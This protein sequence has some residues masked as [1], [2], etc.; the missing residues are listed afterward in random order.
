[1]LRI[2]NPGSDIDGFI[3]IFRELFD[4]LRTLETFDPDDMSRVLV[5]RNLVTSSGF[6]G[7]AALARSYRRDR[8][9]DA[10]YNQSK[11][12]SE[13]LKALGWIHPTA[14]AALKFKF[15]YLGAHAAVARRDP[16]AF[17]SECLLGIVYPNKVLA[18][19]GDL[20]LRPFTA[21]LRTMKALDGLL[22]RDEMIVGPLCLSDDRDEA[23][24]DP[25]LEMLRRIRRN[26]S[27]FVELEQASR[28]WGITLNT[29][30]NYTRFPM[31]ALRWTGW[32]ERKRV[33]DIYGLSMP[34]LV[35]TDKGRRAIAH[36]DLLSDI[37]S[38]DVSSL[39]QDSKDSVVRLGFYQLLDRA[40][41]D[42]RALDD[43]ID[44]DR[45]RAASALSL[46]DPRVLFSP[47]QELSLSYLATVFPDVSGATQR[48]ESGSAWQARAERVTPVTF[49]VTVS[50]AAGHEASNQEVR[51]LFENVLSDAHDRKAAIDELSRRYRRSN[52]DEFYPLVASLFC[53]LGYVCELSRP[54]VN[55]QR[56]DA[57][58]RDSEHTIPIEIKSPGEE[59]CLSV[60]AVR[61]ALENKVVLLARRPF[62]T[63]RH[64]TSLV[65]GYKLPADRS[66]VFSLI[67]DIRSAYDLV[68]G[69]LDFNSL[70]RLAAMTVLDG[71]RHDHNALTN[72]YGIA[73]VSDV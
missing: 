55:A 25:M 8:S 14:Q 7:A 41:F 51:Q 5:E 9:R 40:G 59:E 18:A 64:T 38:D 31:A 29:M 39:S 56:Y 22:C 30:A 61:Q 17:F 52:R 49:R 24:I 11:M 66:E 48:D 20:R 71:K 4:A 15:T 53:A 46:D 23:A 33:S 54:G 47:F 45:R 19:R 34:F 27:L 35:L 13:L 44:H 58:I 62:P 28:R 1:M 63:R 42:V 67:R 50:T 26:R 36:L 68:I 6:M 21:I 10:L 3:R 43:Q 70:L 65:V 37:R 12:Y 69:I 60:K 16:V 2:P 73:D 57:I 72:L 32:A